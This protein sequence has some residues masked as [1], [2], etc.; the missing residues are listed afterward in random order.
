[1]LVSDRPS[2]NFDECIAHIH[3]TNHAWKLAQTWGETFTALALSLA[4]RKARLQADL[5]RHHPDR[6]YLQRDRVA[7]NEAG[8]PLFGVL[9]DPPIERFSDAAH[10]P[11]RVAH[12]Y[13][14]AAE[15]DR[16][17]RE[18]LIEELEEEPKIAPEPAP[19]QALPSVDTSAPDD[20]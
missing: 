12:R 13:L 11:V 5:L 3:V 7:E 9:L 15:I 17:S 8:E 10:L 4:D 6:V 16:F 18:L 14:S 1:L 19:I 20:S 2:P